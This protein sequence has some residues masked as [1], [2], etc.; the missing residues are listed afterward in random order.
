[1]NTPSVG[2]T[3]INPNYREASLLKCKCNFFAALDLLKETL[4]S[5][6]LSQF[7]TIYLLEIVLK[8]EHE[9]KI[10]KINSKALQI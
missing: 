6:I 5:K 9:I 2:R 8:E 3:D 10:L 1:M 4:H 7:L